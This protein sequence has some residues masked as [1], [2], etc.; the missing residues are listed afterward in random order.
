MQPTAYCTNAQIFFI[1]VSL[2]LLRPTVIGT[3]SLRIIALLFPRLGSVLPFTY[4]GS[5]S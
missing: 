2:V 3:Y 4:R 1:F 5:S